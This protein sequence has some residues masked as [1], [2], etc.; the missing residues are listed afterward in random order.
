MQYDSVN[1]YS[2]TVGNVHGSNESILY[3]GE[4]YDSSFN[5][6]ADALTENPVGVYGFDTT[7]TVGENNVIVESATTGI[8][9]AEYH[10]ET[11][12]MMVYD[13]TA[14]TNANAAFQSAVSLPV[15]AQRLS[16]LSY[17]PDTGELSVYDSSDSKLSDSYILPIASL[18]RQTRIIKAMSELALNA[19]TPQI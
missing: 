8:V 11:A 16:R 19:V 18:L 15:Q 3:N 6:L 5:P 12:S 1:V 17:D 10:G 2:I 7:R 14:E 13:P 9:S 4:E